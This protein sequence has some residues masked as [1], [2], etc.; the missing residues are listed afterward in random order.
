[1]LATYYNVVI[2]S[3]FCYWP[4][5]SLY[6][7]N[8]RLQVSNYILCLLNYTT[9]ASLRSIDFASRKPCNRGHHR[10]VKNAS[11]KTINSL[12][13]IYHLV[14]SHYSLSTAPRGDTIPYLHELALDGQTGKAQNNSWACTTIVTAKRPRGL[15]ISFQFNFS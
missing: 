5:Y 10:L 9:G 6:R 15:T 7:F 11:P 1:M 12:L 4:L 13:N 14:V 8:K 2:A 3:K